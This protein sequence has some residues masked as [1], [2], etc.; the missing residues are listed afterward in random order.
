MPTVNNTTVTVKAGT[1]L[2]TGGSFTTNQS[3]ASTITL[4]HS[5]SVTAGTAKGSD[6][7]TL[8]L[9]DS[10]AIPTISYDAQGHITGSSYTTI[11]MP[12][13]SADITGNA[14]SA[15]KWKTA[16]NFS[17]TDGAGHTGNI[18][19]VN[20][21]D[22]VSLDLPDT[23][24]ANIESP[25]EEYLFIDKANNVVV[26]ISKDG[27]DTTDVRTPETSLNELKEAFDTIYTTPV[28]TS[29]AGVVPVADAAIGTIDNQ[30]NDWVLTKNDNGTVDWYK[31]PANAFKDTTYE[32]ANTSSAGLAQKLCGDSTKYYRG[33]GAWAVPPDTKYTAGDGLTLT[34]T[35]FEITTA[36][37]SE[38]INKLGEGTSEAKL[39]DYLVA[40]YA[41]GGETTTTYHR[42]KVSNIVNATVVKNALGTGTGT[43]KYLRE[44]GTW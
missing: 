25:E 41:G 2:K 11:T 42:R 20:G 37:A 18:T 10:F 30:A 38:I 22:N 9:G 24:V 35:K 32:V 12:P 6:N 31:L 36:D 5:N 28:S 3:S 19:S 17:I 21:S 4:D 43:T 23:I 40:Q 8:T 15:D 16:R 39:D 14:G 7:K 26:K 13:K 44:D 27:I 34:G 33:D 1:G 29:K